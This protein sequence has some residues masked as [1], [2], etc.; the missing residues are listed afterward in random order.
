MG[1]QVMLSRSSSYDAVQAL[2]VV[3]AFSAFKR[4]DALE[5]ELDGFGE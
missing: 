1:M 5:R 3:P 4:S 2:T